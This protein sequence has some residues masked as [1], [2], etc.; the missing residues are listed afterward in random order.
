ML[1]GE[2]NMNNQDPFVVFN[3]NI[4]KATD[5]LLL[6]ELK[7]LRERFSIPVIEQ[8]RPIRQMIKKW[9]AEICKVGLPQVLVYSV[10]C[11]DACI[12]NHYFNLNGDKE[13]YYRSSFQ[14]PNFVQD[15][16]N[17]LTESE[18]NIFVNN[19]ELELKKNWKKIVEKRNEIVHEGK[20]PSLDFETIG[21]YIDTIKNSVQLMQQKTSQLEREIIS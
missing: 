16:F 8:Y 6:A 1:E 5:F 20:V 9:T 3:K 7:E 4:K 21:G 12:K 19:E 18:M 14:N 15:R 11:L 10:S 13:K 17:E 2:E